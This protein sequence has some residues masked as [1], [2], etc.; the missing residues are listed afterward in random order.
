MLLFG[1]TQGGI[2]RDLRNRAAEALTQLPFDGYAIG[3]LSVGE[4]IPEM[5]DVLSYHPESLPHDRVRYLMGVGTP[6]DIVQAVASG[7][8]LFDCVIPTRSGRFSRAYVKGTPPFINVRNA[9]YADS[10][11]PLDENCPCLACRRYT[12]GYL[13]HLFRVDEMLGPILL[14]IHNLQHY[15][16]LMG[17]IRKA[18]ESR[19]FAVLYQSVMR[20]WNA[21]Q[22]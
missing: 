9:K 7:V 21:I 12:L 5:D 14:S 19:T 17:S 20:D 3:G 1:I 6:R 18:I 16:D 13:H 10:T 8:D 15:L 11:E 4:P 22:E 2:F